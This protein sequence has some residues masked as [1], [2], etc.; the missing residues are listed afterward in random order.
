MLV[1]SENAQ[2]EVFC[3]E[4]LLASA[5]AQRSLFYVVLS[6]FCVSELSVNPLNTSSFVHIF[7]KLV[8]KGEDHLTTGFI[9]PNCHM[10]MKFT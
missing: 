10:L 4:I 1:E 5:Q 3:S 2:L 7:F 6:D 8:M 9:E